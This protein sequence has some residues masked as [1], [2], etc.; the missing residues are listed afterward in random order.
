MGCVGAIKII[1]HI[2][3]AEQEHWRTIH[4]NF[5]LNLGLLTLQEKLLKC[6]NCI[7][8]VGWKIKSGLS[9]REGLL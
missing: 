6:K 2:G 5:I 1:S 8:T 3:N 7:E 9:K 4:Q